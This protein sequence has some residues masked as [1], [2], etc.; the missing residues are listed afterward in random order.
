MSL[1]GKN[2]TGT[3]YGMPTGERGKAQRGFPNI[4][5]RSPTDDVLTFLRETD[6][7]HG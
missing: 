3:T 1:T 4:N 5:L 2:V 7:I 6:V